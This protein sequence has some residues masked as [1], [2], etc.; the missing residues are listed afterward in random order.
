LFRHI[1]EYIMV[2]SVR[3]IALVPLSWGEMQVLGRISGATSTADLTG[4]RFWRDGGCWGNTPDALRD[5]PAHDSQSL[6]ELREELRHVGVELRSISGGVIIAKAKGL[7]QLQVW[8][9]V[10]R[11]C[12]LHDTKFHPFAWSSGWRNITN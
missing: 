11:Y 2:K 10:R 8:Y 1:E 12:A 5:D 9:V 7:K 6:T 3:R 4:S